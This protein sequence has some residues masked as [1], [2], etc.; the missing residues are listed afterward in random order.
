MV[1]EQGSSKASSY[2]DIKEPLMHL[3]ILITFLGGHIQGGIYINSVRNARAEP[4]ESI[5]P[6]FFISSQ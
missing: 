3:F 1:G 2:T 5:N 4:G 6:S